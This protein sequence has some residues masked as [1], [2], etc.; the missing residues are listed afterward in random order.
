[1]R[2]IDKFLSFIS[3]KTR[4]GICQAKLWYIKNDFSEIISTK[5]WKVFNKRIRKNVELEDK[6]EDKLDTI[7]SE[8]IENL[9]TNNKSCVTLNIPKPGSTNIQI[10]EE[11]KSKIDY[12]VYI[13]QPFSEHYD[14]ESN[15]WNELKNIPKI[16]KIKDFK[17]QSLTKS[18]LSEEINK[19]ISNSKKQAMN[20]YKKE[21]EKSVDVFVKFTQSQIKEMEKSNDEEG[22]GISF[23][24]DYPWF[25]CND[26]IKLYK[27]SRERAM[28]VHFIL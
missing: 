19:I 13:D 5:K 20:E 10:S 24:N 1:M 12:I 23:I 11:Y 25:N 17:I 2:K 4:F 28:N 7:S 3:K 8:N 26:A 16:K 15:K 18:F 21:V 9:I 27:N 6:K 14:N 22:K